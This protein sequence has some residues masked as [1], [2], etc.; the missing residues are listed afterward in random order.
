MPTESR[1]RIVL[2]NTLACLLLFSPPAKPAGEQPLGRILYAQAASLRGLAVP[3]SETILSG[4]VVTTFDAG[5]ALVELKSGARLKIVENSSVRFIGDGDKVQAELLGGAVVSESA[6]NSKLVVTT[7]KFQFAPSQEGSSRYAVALSK[8]AETFAGA[9]KGDLLVKK[10]DSVGSYILREGEY[11]AIPASSVDVPLQGKAE[12]QPVSAGQAGTVTAAVPQEVIQRQGQG[13]EI[14]LKVTDSVYLAD[15]VRTSKSGQ[16]RIALLGGTLLN[17][18]ADTTMR[19]S[20][21]DVQTQ[22][23]LIE[24]TTGVVRAEVAKLTK[25]GASFQI[26]T[27]TAKIGIVGTVISVQVLPNSTIVCSLQGVLTVQNIDPNIPGQVTL[28]PDQC[29]TV[30]RGLPPTPPWQMPT[31]QAWHIGSLSE[32]NSILLLVAIGAVGTTAI[33]VPLL[34][35]PVVPF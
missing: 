20:K 21:H 25:P 33:A 28:Q 5:S 2:A 9:M 31:E 4:D 34:T 16:V 22:Q 13:A 10:P 1:V 26:Q 23:T 8:E 27:T 29:T 14:P 24:V 15:V 17:V 35:S 12:S 19:I 30:N 7:S 6:G 18:G 32:T 3:G 11:A